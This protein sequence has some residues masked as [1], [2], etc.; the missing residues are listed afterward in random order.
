[1]I[2]GVARVGHDV[3][4]KPP[5]HIY[6]DTPIDMYMCVYI[7][8]YIKLNHFVVYLKHNIVNQLYLIKNKYMKT[9][10]SLSHTHSIWAISSM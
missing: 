8:I 10:I 9:R 2:I 7:Y 4:T 3:A 6:T 5:P 1:M